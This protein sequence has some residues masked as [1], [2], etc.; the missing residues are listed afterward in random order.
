MWVTWAADHSSGGNDGYT[1]GNKV[2]APSFP[3]SLWGNYTQQA[4]YGDFVCIMETLDPGH[5]FAAND[6][7]EYFFM[8]MMTRSDG[9]DIAGDLKTN[10]VLPAGDSSSTQWTNSFANSAFTTDNVNNRI[11]SLHLNYRY[12]R[13][14]KFA[15]TGDQFTTS[16]SYDNVTWTTPTWSSWTSDLWS[17][18]NDGVK[19]DVTGNDGIIFWAGTSH[20]QNL[21]SVAN[22]NFQ[23]LYDGSQS[24]RL[25]YLAQ[26]EP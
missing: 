8:G 13:Y 22:T 26:N 16:Y 3:N 24:W 19:T 5:P 17:H 21:N 4:I 23:D 6:M 20:S 25:L 9:V 11:A 1:E 15:R 2:W 18:Y 14:I 10:W 12:Y 7:N